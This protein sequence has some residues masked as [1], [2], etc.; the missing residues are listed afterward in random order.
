M[1]SQATFQDAIATCT[2]W[3]RLWDDGEL[4]DEVLADLVGKLVFDRDGARGFFVV[5]LTGESPLMDRLP[6]ALIIQLRLVGESVVDLTA[7]NLVMST[8]MGIQHSRDNNQALLEG[9]LRVQRRSKELLSQLEPQLVKERVEE[10]LRGLDGKSE[11]INFFQR[12]GYDA[13]QKDAI[14][15]MLLSIAL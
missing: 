6:E 4:S 1:S 3:I 14:K 10:M 2:N 9:S 15:Q 5:S 11:D 13:Q 7:R 8:A 12:W